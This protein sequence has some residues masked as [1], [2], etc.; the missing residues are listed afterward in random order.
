MNNSE[1][2]NQIS[3][4]NRRA[5]SGSGLFS[6]KIF[7]FLLGGIALAALIIIVGS[8]LKNVSNKEKDLVEQVDIRVSNL[9]ASITTYKSSLKSSRLR[10]M[11][12][13]LSGVLSNTSRDVSTLLASVYDYSDKT[14][15]A[16]TSETELAHITAF[17]ST[18]DEAKINGI[19]DRTWVREMALQIALL[20]SI[21]SEAKARTSNSG[22]A[23]TLESSM[24]DLNQLYEQFLSYSDATN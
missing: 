23:A 5:K 11:T 24:S 18:M 1:Y 7:K 20:I 9:S 6:G 17:N 13:S 2:L 14:A 8:L 22:V 4:D 16:T 12:A 15:N 21:E 19:L 3:L 10:A